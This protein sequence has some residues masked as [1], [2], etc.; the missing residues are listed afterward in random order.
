MAELVT[1]EAPI[2]PWPRILRQQWV[3]LSFLHWAVD[4]ESIAHLYPAGTEPDTFEGSSFV[5]VVPFQMKFF[6]MFLETNVR[7]YSVDRTGRR[8]VVFLS[9]DT[10]RLDVVAGGRWIFGLPYRLARMDYREQA[11]RRIY[12]ST[13]RWPAKSA[14]S[15]VE[16]RVGDGLVA[17]PLE[18]FLTARW[19][20]HVARGG[21]TWYMPN[22]HPV[23]ALR[24]AELIG[25]DDD[26]LL[27]SVGLGELGK[28][29][30]DHATF[31]DGVAAR[32]GL[33]VRSTTP[34]AIRPPRR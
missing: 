5:G 14:S 26:G 22:E 32:F 11:D 27:A 30:P 8:G 3:N 33:P 13:V 18:H 20:L 23:W 31:S 16:V 10:N 17:G 25:F 24:R 2:L 28:R 12:T 7:L 1:A 4:P 29:P 34:R 21:R 15:R 9:L 19:G 6:G